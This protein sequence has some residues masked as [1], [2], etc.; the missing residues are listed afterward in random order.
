MV[1]VHSKLII[2]DDNRT[3][4]G[5]A[6][7]NDRSMLGERDAE[8]AFLVEDQEFEESKMNGQPYACGKFSG[9][10][11]KRLMKYRLV[12]YLFAIY[13]F[14]GCFFPLQNL[15]LFIGRYAW[16]CIRRRS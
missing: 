2:V 14:D 8:I 3:I 6:N 10:T 12:L 5:S 7:I 13:F 16:R 11:R 1:Y 4:I 15:P 9:R